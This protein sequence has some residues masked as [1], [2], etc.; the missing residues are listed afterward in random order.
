[1]TYP[2][3]GALA[4][5]IRLAANYEQ[6]FGHEPIGAV[7]SNQNTEVPPP[8]KNVQWRRPIDNGDQRATRPP[9]Q[10]YQRD[11]ARDNRDN[12]NWPRQRDFPERRNQPPPAAP[13]RQIAPMNPPREAP[14]PPPAND[15]DTL[16]REMERLRI[17]IAELQRPQPTAN[18]T[19]FVEH[20]QIMEQP[21]PEHAT[22]LYD[23]FT[24]PFPVYP[25][26]ATKRPAEAQPEA[27]P[28]P[29]R[30]RPNNLEHT[31]VDPRNPPRPAAP[32]PTPSQHQPHEPRTPAAPAPAPARGPAA[33]PPAD[34]G[35]LPPLPN[36]ARPAAYRR[37]VPIAPATAEPIQQIKGLPMK[38]TVQTY[39]NHISEEEL[40]KSMKELKESREEFLRYR[41]RDQPQARATNAEVINISGGTTSTSVTEDEESP[42]AR[43]PQ[44]N[45][46]RNPVNTTVATVPIIINNIVFEDGIIDTGATNTMISQSA[47]RQLN[48][49]DQI[50]PS[51]LRYS[52]ADGKMSSPWGIIRKLP[53][54]VEGLV[55]PIDVFVSGATSYDVLLGT[56]WL[57][58]AHAEISFAKQEMSFRIIPHILGRVP[59]TVMPASKS[60]NRYCI[61]Q[62]PELDIGG[63]AEHPAHPG[64]PMVPA[65]PEV[66]NI[67]DITS[68]EE[69]DPA[70]SQDEVTSTNI[71][72]S[73]EE[74]HYPEY[75]IPL[76]TEASAACNAAINIEEKVT[77][78][79]EYPDLSEERSLKKECFND[80]NKLWGPFDIDACCDTNGLNAQ[81]PQYW[82]PLQDCLQQSWTH[83]KVYCN[84]P[85]SRIDDIVSHCLACFE[86]SPHT[87]S[88]VLVLPCWPDAPWF[89]KVSQQFHVVKEYPKGSEIAIDIGCSPEEPDLCECAIP[90][91]IIVVSTHAATRIRDP[92]LPQVI[93]VPAEAVKHQDISL[94]EVPAQ[95]KSAT[96]ESEVVHVCLPTKP[97]DEHSP[98]SHERSVYNMQ[99]PHS[100]SSFKS[101]SLQ[102]ST[103]PRN[104]NADLCN[105]IDSDHYGP[106]FLSAR[107]IC[108][109]LDAAHFKTTLQDSTWS[110][111]PSLGR[112]HTT[113]SVL[114][115]V[116]E[117]S[118]ILTGTSR[119]GLVIH[120]SK[121]SK[122][123]L[124]HRR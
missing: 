59:I 107:V 62:V 40:N 49:I 15:I 11:N 1:M 63:P 48:L 53:V 60:S 4:E 52:C 106:T 123:T 82:S 88:A 85:F 19:K 38:L 110:A 114:R 97:R 94:L 8:E 122:R 42:S 47:A 28:P 104:T 54:G 99:K 121:R 26:Y 105:T 64:V 56:D 33:H 25:I 22:I 81:L 27:D 93:A 118:T 76:P 83:K 100:D 35:G 90:W 46:Q 50:E 113:C 98:E 6:T 70:A 115:R 80:L 51:R 71:S 24:D 74:E 20:E 55:I 120:A 32:R 69:E 116:S 29:L 124:Y 112:M 36:A 95:P 73:T 23:G 34:L 65:E 58:Q 13:P 16:T 41:Q 17:Q 5:I 66:I 92:S 109:S 91:P 77:T 86:A 72:D 39:L 31:T 18:F 101:F 44:L 96:V 78:P 10:Q 7:Y 67:N 103:C 12:R 117:V 87:T 43:A 79:T 108:P 102:T 21:P 111:K 9:Q 57:T 14:A 84:P 30:R 37:P 68:D 61:T 75:E 45:L 3:N 89:S 119:K 2:G